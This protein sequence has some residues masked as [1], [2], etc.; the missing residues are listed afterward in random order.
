MSH[1]NKNLK[2]HND[3]GVYVIAL[4]IELQNNPNRTMAL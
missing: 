4:L 3:T 1:V 2:M